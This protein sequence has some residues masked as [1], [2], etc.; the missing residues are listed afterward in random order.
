MSLYDAVRELPLEIEATTSTS[1]E[2]EARADFLRKTTIIRFG[3]AARKGSART[4]PT[5]ATE[6]DAQLGAR[7]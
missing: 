2:L 4:S 3:A 7:A 1:L 6:H 5:T